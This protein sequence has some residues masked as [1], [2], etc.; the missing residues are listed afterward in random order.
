MS[1]LATS[2]VG[3]AA[4]LYATGA[5]RRKLA[6]GRTGIRVAQLGCF[7]AALGTLLIATSSPLVPAGGR[8]LS[9]WSLQ[10]QLLLAVAAPLLA[11]ARPFE[12][13]ADSLPLGLRLPLRR[14][15]QAWL[16]SDW[17]ATLAAPSL[18]C[19]LHAL[20][21]SAW[22][23]PDAFATLGGAPDGPAGAG[24]FTLQLASVAIGVAFWR[25]A[26]ERDIPRASALA[27]L[28]VTAAQLAILGALLMQPAHTAYPGVV[29]ADQRFAVLLVCLGA[30]VV[31][32]VAALLLAARELAS[33]AR[34]ARLL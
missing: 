18:L 13:W 27:M 28:I 10:Q 4:A 14:A 7:V 24:L 31:Y 25:R 5:L 34:L 23:V 11:L 2:A 15:R 19:A 12:A 9:A 33:P 20:L 22:F 1:S 30:L 3:L 29:L 8:F 17:R 32:P 21:A 26:L 16:R 6:A